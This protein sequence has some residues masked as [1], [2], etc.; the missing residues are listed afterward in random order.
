[1][2]VRLSSFV[3][4]LNLCHTSHIA[5]V[6]RWKLAV[7]LTLC[8]SDISGISRKVF[9][10]PLS[11]VWS[12]KMMASLHL[13]YQWRLKHSFLSR[14][15]LLNLPL[16]RT[17]VRQVKHTSSISQK[18]LMLGASLSRCS[19]PAGRLLLLLL[20]GLHLFTHTVIRNCRQRMML[21]LL[22]AV[23]NRRID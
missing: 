11:I 13:K 3:M 7:L 6:G 10:W 20:L 4:Y 22:C 19:G 8:V 17:L 1:M 23:K 9:G 18:L 5:C 2:Q 12:M 14:L 15:V 16:A 21:L